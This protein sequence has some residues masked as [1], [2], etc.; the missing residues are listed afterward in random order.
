[1]TERR[2][3]Q[4]PQLHVKFIDFELFNHH[5]SDMDEI[6]KRINQGCQKQKQHPVGKFVSV[7]PVNP[8]YLQGI[9]GKTLIKKNIYWQKRVGI[10][11]S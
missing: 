3:I 6:F 2:F 11:L 10:Y 1:M 4:S 8:E 5:L 7:Y 9:P